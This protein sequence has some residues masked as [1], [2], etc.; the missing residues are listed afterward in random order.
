VLN[1]GPLLSAPLLASPGLTPVTA[2]IIATAPRPTAHLAAGYGQTAALSALAPRPSARLLASGQITAVLSAVEAR[3]SAVVGAS[4]GVGVGVAILGL[5]ARP[6]ALLSSVQGIGT[7][8]HA[9][10]TEPTSSTFNAV[11]GTGAT[12][13]ASLARPTASFSAAQ[14]ISASLVSKASSPVGVLGGTRGVGVTSLQAFTL[15]STARIQT[16]QG[17]SAA[18]SGLASEPSAHLFAGP[19]N[20]TSAQILTSTAAPSAVITAYASNPIPAIGAILSY[21]RHTA[22]LHPGVIP[23]PPFVGS[24][25]GGSVEAR[26]LDFTP[27]LLP[28]GSGILSVLG[29]SVQRIDGAPMTPGDLTITP[30][31]TAGPWLSGSITNAAG[32]SVGA[33]IVGWW[34][35]AAAQIAVSGPVYYKV[36]ITVATSSGETPLTRDCYQIVTNA[37]G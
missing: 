11:F 16:Q 36:S 26:Q 24:L 18:L 28:L 15:P 35:T 14:G 25:R 27:E 2:G 13:R 17:V 30:P 31:G 34:E 37:L 9:A 1:F 20:I 22:S 3:P 4:S 23:T 10:T 29:I 6:S 21:L 32:I 7:A 5:A 12:I 19:T 33:A 8:I